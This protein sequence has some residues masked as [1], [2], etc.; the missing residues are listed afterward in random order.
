MYIGN[1]GICGH[2]LP[3]LC[4]EDQPTQEDRSSWHEI[5]KNQMDFRLGLTVGFI[6]G[7]WTIFCSLLFK[8]DWMYTCFSL[9]NKL[10]D[11]VWIFSVVTWQQWLRNPGTI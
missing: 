2:P 7:L 11:K 3:K 1:P 5:E 10:F 8:K 9:L 4:P 6:V